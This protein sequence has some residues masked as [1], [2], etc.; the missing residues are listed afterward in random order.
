[1]HCERSLRCAEIDVV[2]GDETS[3]HVYINMWVIYLGFA[4][5]LKIKLVWDPLTISSY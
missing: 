3:W 1:M 4:F 2:D 5:A